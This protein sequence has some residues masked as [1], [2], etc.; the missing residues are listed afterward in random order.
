VFVIDTNQQPLAP[1]HPARARILLS[2]GKAAVFKRYPF[3]LILK[4]AVEQ[5][6]C[7][8]F[9]LKLD[10]GSQTTGL[11]TVN[12]RTGEVVFAAE[13]SHRGQEI[14]KR[15]SERRA[16]RR[17][18]RQRQTR[19]RKPRFDN[20]KNKK[21]GWLPPSLES[22][23]SNI[24]TWVRRLRKLCPISAISQ[25]LVKF[26]TQL[27]ENAEITGVQYQQGT[28]AGYE[29]RQYLL[30]K[31]GR[32]CAYCG[33]SHVPLEVE[34]IQARSRSHDNRVS[35]LTLA[36]RACNEA[37]GTQDVRVFLKDRPELAEKLL[38]AAK[39]PLRDAAAVNATR[40]A[41]YERLKAVGLP[42]ECGSGGLTKYNRTMRGLPKEHW[43]DASCV[44]KKTPAVV[45]VKGVIP[46]LIEATGHGSRQMCGT[47]KYGF[48]TRH[49]SRSKRHYGFATGEMVRAVVPSGKKAGEYVGRVLVR[50]SGSFDLQT[51]G[52][53]VQGINH[54]SCRI[55]LHGDGYRYALGS[56]SAP[57]PQ[58]ECLLPP[59]LERQG[60]PQAEVL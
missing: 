40:W 39:R 56:P 55:I 42:V 19:Y 25:E 41:L 2:S 17:S 46:L 15:L 53:R 4:R 5:P 12:E 60:L 38:K 34:H 28:L 3:T 29:V 31:W 21:P 58:K 11:A 57:S 27:M 20:R 18:R 26:D 36:C 48:P 33:K 50:A 54:R 43:I 9:R 30:E 52:G 22:R 49:R 7:D 24:L 35:N 23:I 47:N 16:V 10:P 51:C 1:T 8:P 13:I 32:A 59:L 45:Q 37:K 6:V 14:Q 44:G